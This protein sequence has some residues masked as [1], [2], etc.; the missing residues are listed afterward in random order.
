M[1]VLSEKSSTSTRDFRRIFLPVRQGG[2]QDF[3]CPV[4]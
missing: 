4:Q 2:A 1:V 3:V